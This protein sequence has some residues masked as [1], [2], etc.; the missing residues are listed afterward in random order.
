[1]LT[2]TK[3]AGLLGI[4]G[5]I[6]TVECHSTRSLPGFEIVGLPDAAVKE[7][8]QRVNTAIL[9]TGISG[10]DIDVHINL[11]PADMKKEGS[12]LDL[13]IAVSVLH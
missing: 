7:S 8:E 12:A 10:G 13:A 5:F 9:N 3:G 4:D 6:V 2:V 11:A 1:M